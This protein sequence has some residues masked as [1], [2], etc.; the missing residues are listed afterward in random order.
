MTKI[1]VRTLESVPAEELAERLCSW[2]GR[3]A[4]SEFR[5]L[6]IAAEFDRRGLYQRWECQ[7]C[8]QWLMWQCS[9]DIRAAHDKVRVARAIETLPV[10]SASFAVGELSY[11][12]VR[13]LT[14]VATPADEAEW[15]GIAQSL[16]TTGLERIVAATRRAVQLNRGTEET[17]QARRGVTSRFEEDGMVTTTVRLAIDE[18]ALLAKAIECAMEPDPRRSAEQRRADALVHV[19]AG[20][21][22][23][24]NGQDRPMRTADR[25]Q[26]VVHVDATLLADDG[27]GAAGGGRGERG[28]GQDGGGAAGEG[29]N[30]GGG[31]GDGGVGGDGGDGEDSSDIVHEGEATMAG[32]AVPIETVQRLC[33]DGSVVWL[34]ESPDGEPL[35]ASAKTRTV[36]ASLRRAL[37]ARDRMCRFPGCTNTG[38]LDAH[39]LIHWIHGGPTTLN[40]LITLCRHHHRSVHEGHWT[41]THCDQGLRFTS[42]RG[43]SLQPLTPQINDH[44]PDPDLDLDLDLDLHIGPTAIVPNWFGDPIDVGYITAVMLQGAAF[45]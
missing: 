2:A 40:N 34:V 4:A 13:A 1:D 18:H 27:G 41:I 20:F 12:K 33:C 36:P 3:A 24:N 30:G 38:W 43:W 31:R 21:L 45:T 28:S 23:T 22:A 25:Y 42:Q 44:D 5:W 37:Q 39:H 29:S 16:P 8:A 35:G 9:L 15:V 32:R 6:Q 17:R 11:S 26:T 14:R 7:T 19:A 10:T